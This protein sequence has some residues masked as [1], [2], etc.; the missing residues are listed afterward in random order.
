MILSNEMLEESWDLHM[1]KGKMIKDRESIRTFLERDLR[2]LKTNRSY[3]QGMETTFRKV[4]DYRKRDVKDAHS[5]FLNKTQEGLTFFN[6]LVQVKWFV[7]E[8][9]RRNFELTQLEQMRQGLSGDEGKQLDNEYS[10]K[11]RDTYEFLKKNGSKVKQMCY[12]VVS[13]CIGSNEDAYHKYPSG[14]GELAKQSYRLFTR[15]FW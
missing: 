8:L 2:R 3:Q 15:R 12:V 11:L 7:E 14:C 1:R 6:Y 5:Y 10:Q 4:T 9:K 13:G